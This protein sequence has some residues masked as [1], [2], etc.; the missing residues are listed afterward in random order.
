VIGKPALPPFWALGWQQASWT[1]QDQATVEEVIANYSNNYIPLEVMW[2]DIP[3]MDNYADFSVDTKA[4]PDLAGLKT[5]LADK[6]QRLV[7]ILDGGLSADDTAN[8]Y[9][10]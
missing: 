9:Y 6:G 3:Y 4:F 7:V 10:Q 1:Y 8:E 5:Q 2:L